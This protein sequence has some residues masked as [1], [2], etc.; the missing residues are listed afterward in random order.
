MH[1]LK[2]M[3]NTSRRPSTEDPGFRKVIQYKRNIKTIDKEEI[4]ETAETEE[5][6]RLRKQGNDD[7]DGVRGTSDAGGDN[8]DDDQAMPPAGGGKNDGDKNNGDKNNGDK[9]NDVQGK[10]VEEEEEGKGQE[11]GVGVEQQPEA[12]TSTGKKRVINKPIDSHMPPSHLKRQQKAGEPLRGLP[13][14]GGT[15]LFGYKD[16]WAYE[17]YYTLDHT[18]F[19]PYFE[20]PSFNFMMKKWPLDNNVM[21]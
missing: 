5:I 10:I 11:I 17:I 4:I 9:D 8:D 2:R 21:S 3:K 15:V 7:D 16:S 14:D 20:A 1:N 13:E 18:N 6:A 12:A 19:H